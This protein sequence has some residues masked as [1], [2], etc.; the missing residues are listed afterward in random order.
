MHNATPSPYSQI[1]IQKYAYLKFFSQINKMSNPRQNKN[2]DWIFL[3]F[4]WRTGTYIKQV[5]G[6]IQ[7]QILIIFFQTNNLGTW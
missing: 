6:L 7:I 4:K 3:I 2:K 1:I 5:L